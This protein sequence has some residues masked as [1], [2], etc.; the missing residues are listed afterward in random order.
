MPAHNSSGFTVR[1]DAQQLPLTGSVQ[2]TGQVSSNPSV[3]IVGAGAVVSSGDFTSSPALG[4]LVSIFG[5]GLADGSAGNTGLPLPQ[6]IGSTSVV[7]SGRVLPLLYV[8]PTQVNVI[9]PYD[10][11][12]NM[13]QQL[14]V[15]RGNAT[16]VP[17]P[18]AVFASEP[19]ILAAAN[20]QG[21]I[22]KVDAL[23]NAVLADA[24]APATAGDA[25]VIYA[26]GL[27]AVTPAL[28]AG[29][30]APGS[31]F[32]QTAVPVTATIG[33][34]PASVFFAGLT[35]GFVGLYQVNVTVPTGITAGS[36]VPVTVSVAGKSNAGSVYMAVH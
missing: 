30:G 19:A 36:S 8:S 13:A 31:P 29:D 3:P 5:S 32:S 6:H 10:V 24:N 26:V 15:L 22:Y 18:L 14:V 17:V 27:G 12:V 28:T 33:G 4:L 20:G 34:V 7:L 35:P 1:A 23:G 9:I 2:V 25:L 11:P 16:S 21:A